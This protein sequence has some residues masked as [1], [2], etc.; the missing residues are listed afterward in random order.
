VY[1]R[2]SERKRRKQR[3]CLHKASHVI[4]DKL[5]ERAVVIGDLSQRQMVRKKHQ[6]QE[7]P[8]ER[9]KRRIRNRSVYNDWGLYGFVQMLE[10]KCLLSGKELHIIDERDTTKMCHVCQR[11]KDMP[12]WM[13]TYRCGNCGLV[14]DR[15]DNSAINIY[16]RFLAGLPPHK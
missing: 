10:Y 2:V 7:T 8:Q 12:L 1:K 15:D 16:Q 4:A 13:R 5:A 14:M 11:K 9:R 6:E 3:D